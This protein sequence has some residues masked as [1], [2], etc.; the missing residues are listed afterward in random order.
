[1]KWLRRLWQREAQDKESMS[2]FT[3]IEKRKFERLLSM[4]GGT[5]EARRT[6]RGKLSRPGRTIPRSH[7]GFPLRDGVFSGAD[8]SFPGGISFVPVWIMISCFGITFF[9]SR[10]T[11]SPGDFL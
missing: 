1:M 9:A 7:K 2:S 11:K 4:G 6:T 10:I 8:E 5:G 3:H